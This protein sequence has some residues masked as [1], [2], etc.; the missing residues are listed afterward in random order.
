MDEEAKW[1]QLVFWGTGGMLF[2][3]L[4]E[5]SC[6]IDEISL[7]VKRTDGPLR[8]CDHHRSRKNGTAHPHLN[9]RRECIRVR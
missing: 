9:T 7:W 1:A 2:L 8:R 6:P 5:D 4:H 3:D